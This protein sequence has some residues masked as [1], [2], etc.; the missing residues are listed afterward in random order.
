MALILGA[1]GTGTTLTGVGALIGVPSLAGAV[2]ATGVSVIAKGSATLIRG[3]LEQQFYAAE[4]NPGKIA[5]ELGLAREQRFADS[6]GGSVAKGS[7]GRDLL[8]EALNNPGLKIRIDILGPNNELG[9]VGG[10]G[11][12]LNLARLGDRLSTLRKVAESR[13][14]G[15]IAAFEEG[16]PES[17]FEL[18][19]R[20]L[21]ASNVYR[22]PR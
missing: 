7:D 19:A 15:F 9:L 2:G 22:F 14:V 20:K 18:A 4:T 21:G 16:T 17:V 12:A 1:E 8:V 11:K 13:G 10:P 3:L 5:N 6:I